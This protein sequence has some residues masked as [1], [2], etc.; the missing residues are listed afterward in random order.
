MSSNLVSNL[1]NLQS[2]M[3][4][5]KDKVEVD[6]NLLPNE[7]WLKIIKNAL[8]QCG[9]CIEYHVCFTFESLRLV[10]QQFSNLV[11]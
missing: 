7:I 10:N 4:N 11:N 6:W 8:Q 5:P 9:F 2:D 1:N 3:D